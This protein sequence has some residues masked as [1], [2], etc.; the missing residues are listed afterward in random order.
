MGAVYDSDR[1]KYDPMYGGVNAE[2]N[3]SQHQLDLRVDRSFA[4]KDWKLSGY[5][6]VAN[7]YMNA[8]VVGYDYNT[9]YTERTETTGIP[10]L[11]SIGVRG[12][13]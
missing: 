8:P 13:F 1:N 12:E 6:D 2:R 10:I 4:F 5:L 11:P 9:N 7:V 3:P